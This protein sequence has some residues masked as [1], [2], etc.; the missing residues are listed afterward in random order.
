MAGLRGTLQSVGGAFGP[1]KQKASDEADAREQP[2]ACSLEQGGAPVAQGRPGPPRESAPSGAVAWLRKPRAE[3]GGPQRRRPVLG[4]RVWV[5]AA[6]AAQPRSS[7]G[8]G[9]T[10]GLGFRPSAP[11]SRKLRL[12]GRAGA[13]GAR[14]AGLGC[15]G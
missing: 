6:D 9:P 11:Q 15:V 12:L 4:E 14:R 5:T 3:A 13:R 1:G 7:G 10:S 2:P 8:G